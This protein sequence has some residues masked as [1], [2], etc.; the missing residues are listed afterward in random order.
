MKKSNCLG[1]TTLLTSGPWSRVPCQYIHSCILW[2]HPRFTFP[3]RYIIYIYSYRQREAWTQNNAEVPITIKAWNYTDMVQGGVW[4]RRTE[5][6]CVC[7][8]RERHTRAEY[9]MHLWYKPNATWGVPSFTRRYDL[10][11][12]EARA[13][14][15]PSSFQYSTPTDDS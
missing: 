15:A 10:I 4:R 5:I 13:S 11:G 8:Q 12:N 3:K 6:I 7:F 9:L 14:P 2:G 1:T